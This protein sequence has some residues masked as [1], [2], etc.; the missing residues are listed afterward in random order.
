MR[1]FGLKSS[2]IILCIKIVRL[3]LTRRAFQR[4]GL[5]AI[6]EEPTK[7]LISNMLRFDAG[8]GVC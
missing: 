5:R 4:F 6:R 8:I 3:L 1:T 7:V 2:V